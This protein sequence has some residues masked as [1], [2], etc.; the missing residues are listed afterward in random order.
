[1]TVGIYV[2]KQLGF[3]VGKTADVKPSSNTGRV[4]AKFTDPSVGNEKMDLGQQYYEYPEEAFT[5]DAPRAA[6]IVTD[7]V[8]PIDKR[9]G[10]SIIEA[11]DRMAQEEREKLR[12]PAPSF[13]QPPVAL[14]TEQVA[15][16]L[17]P[18][19][20]PDYQ[21]MVKN[22]LRQTRSPTPPETVHHPAHYGGD[23]PYEAIKVIEAWQLGFALGNA[24]KYI[25][26]HGKKN[27]SPIEDLRKAMWYINWEISQL[28]KEALGGPVKS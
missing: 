10:E 19:A 20:A 13:Q 11:A 17:R 25:A 18:D 2:G 5:F 14:T 6:P 26:R 9:P 1:M 8:I 7:S 24:V 22:Q 4:V 15:S 28:E 16:G 27:T 3:L 21:A 12:T 23:T